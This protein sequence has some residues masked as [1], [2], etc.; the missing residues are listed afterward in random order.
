MASALI[1]VAQRDASGAGHATGEAFETDWPRPSPHSVV[2][3]VAAAD[4]T[5]AVA[6][7]VAVDDR[8]AVAV[9]DPSISGNGAGS[10]SVLLAPPLHFKYSFKLRNDSTKYK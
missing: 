3:V 4:V 1:G 10:S 7:V 8:L 6:A 9:A 5:G 2:A